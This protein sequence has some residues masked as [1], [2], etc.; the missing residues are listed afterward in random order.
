MENTPGFKLS[1]DERQN[2]ISG[3]DQHLARL[4]QGLTMEEN[5][6][7]KKMLH[8]FGTT[9]G[10]DFTRLPQY[11][12]TYRVISGLVEVVRQHYQW[13]GKVINPENPE[14]NRDYFDDIQLSND[15][16]LPWVF[17]FAR[18][19]SL[20]KEGI[21]LISKTRAFNAAAQELQ[22]LLLGDL[23]DKEQTISVSKEIHR[24]ALKRSFLE[25]LQNY[26]LMNWKVG[27][28]GFFAADKIMPMGGETLWNVYGVKYLP[29]NS[30]FEIYVLDI[31][32]DVREPNPHIVEVEKSGKAS[33]S[34]ELEKS[35]I[36][37]IDNTPWY[38]L[39][40]IDDK[41]ESL[42]PV[43]VSRALIGPFEHKYI[44]K[45]TLPVMKDILAE[46]AEACA[47]R[48]SR[49]YSYAPNHTATKGKI[50][51]TIYRENCADEIITIPG[52]FAGK[53]AQSIQGTN[54]RILELQEDKK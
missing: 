3:L 53:M 43:H 46:D 28:T 34:K 23:Q 14:L 18:L 36:F 27:E 7:Q 41:F 47:L 35:F 48:F 5:T 52:K 20:K 17:D 22:L 21:N 40:N 25:Q 33:I 2:Y 12:N 26:P 49:Q 54:L 30:M 24:D 1:G 19:N 10:W 37:G 6:F 4:S 31:W 50:R 16:G 13:F 15:S 29:N 11:S 51:Q 9:N 42:H 32:Q 44:K 8:D 38:V 39:R 45:R